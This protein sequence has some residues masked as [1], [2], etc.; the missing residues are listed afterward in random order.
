M[1]L[2]NSV[3]DTIRGAGGDAIDLGKRVWHAIDGVYTFLKH[4]LENVGG[5]WTKF[6]NAL[7]AVDNAVDHWMGAAFDTMKWLATKAVPGAASWALRKGETVATS[8]VNKAYKLALK[9]IGKAKSEVVGDVKKVE[10]WADKELHKVERDVKGPI[11]WIA[12]TGKKIADLVSHP[13]KMAKFV[14]KALLGPLVNLMLTGSEAVLVD[15]IRGFRRH[16]SDLAHTL[17]DVL[18]KFL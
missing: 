4:I 7:K 14:V 3:W 8:L 17:E 2:L 16:E 15:L 9:E 18:H 13:D 5:A 1:T 12:S 6:Y 10:K 11:N